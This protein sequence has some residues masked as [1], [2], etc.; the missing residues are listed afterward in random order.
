M[1]GVQSNPIYQNIVHKADDIHEMLAPAISVVKAEE[2]IVHKL[3][4]TMND[5]KDFFE[6]LQALTSRYAN[7]LDDP[8]LM[9]NTHRVQN[10]PIYTA[11]TDAILAG[12]N[13]T[14][15]ARDVFIAK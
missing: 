11:Q 5:M 7:M 12:I 9:P 13:E 6:E 10:D 14:L 4:T 2:T 15:D 3:N 8:E 1:R